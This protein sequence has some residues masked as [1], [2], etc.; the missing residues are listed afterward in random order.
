MIEIA[1]VDIYHFSAP[2]E[3]PI[4]TSFGAITA[5]NN[6][7]LRIEDQD[8]AYGWGEIWASFPPCGAENKVRL[9]Q[10]IVLP[11]ALGRSYENP[12]AA[13]H[14]LTRLMRRHA[15][16]SAEPGPFASCLAGIDMAL[17]DLAAR[18]ADVPLWR[19][20]GRDSSPT[21][22]P[23]YASNLNPKGTP[24]M[25]A[26]CRERGYRAFKVKVAFDL[27]SDLKNI[28]T[29][30]DDLKDGECLMLDANQGWEFA[31]ARGAVEAF[32]E[33]PIDWIEEPICVDEPIEHWAELARLSAVPLAGGENMLG[34]AEFDAA[35]D[36]GHLGVIQPDVGKWGGISGCLAVARRAVDAGQR[37]CPHWL[38]S[39][40]GLHASAHL[41]SVAGG[42]GILEHDAMENPLQAP[43]AA[44]FPP[45]IDGCFQLSD[46][47]GLGVEPDLVTASPW[48]SQHIEISA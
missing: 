27:A 7:L 46:R 12:V 36:L 3:E 13:W 15:L 16:Q 9:L 40:L 32:S 21:P 33:L 20:L 17:W 10:S 26:R 34:Q 48:L 43:L 28:R 38:N 42:S 24:E 14:D 44:P 25:I 37:Y 41:L 45:L 2:I 5:R 22:L 6:V 29:I 30:A 1:R 35:V 23:A 19:A 31:D 8:G 39:G 4:V 47:L 11:A 18:K